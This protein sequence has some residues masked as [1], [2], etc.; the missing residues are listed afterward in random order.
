MTPGIAAC[1]VFL[2]FPISRSL[3]KFMSIQSVMLSNHF[4]LSCSLLLLPSIFPTLSVFSSDSALCFRWPE[5]WS[6]NFS[7]SLSMNIQGWFP[8]GLNGLISLLS[9][10]LR[11]VLSST[12]VGKH[13]FSNAPHSLYI[14]HIC[15]WLLEKLYLWVYRHV[16]EKWCFCFLICSI[17]LS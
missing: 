11:R 8:S 13:Q 16:L 15:T 6:F 14:F 2:S 17:V 5:C 9:R 10:G 3:L 12:T 7:I 4:I 1:Q